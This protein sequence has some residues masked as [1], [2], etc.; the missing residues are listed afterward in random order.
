MSVHVRLF[1]PFVAGINKIMQTL[2][3]NALLPGVDTGWGWGWMGGGGGGSYTKYSTLPRGISV[4]IEP[5]V[6]IF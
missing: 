4:Y 5:K 1:I 2:E 6:G 3:S